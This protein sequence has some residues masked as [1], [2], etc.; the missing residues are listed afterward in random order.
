MGAC[1][2]RPQARA[3]VNGYTMPEAV[4]RPP[5]PAFECR[6]RRVV[7]VRKAWG[8]SSEGQQGGGVAGA[9]S[10]VLREK[11][12]PSLWRWSRRPVQLQ[13]LQPEHRA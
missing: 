11:E 8:R 9:S 10:A 7:L 3:P 2:Y 6:K 13:G 1:R 12:A 4:S 5:G